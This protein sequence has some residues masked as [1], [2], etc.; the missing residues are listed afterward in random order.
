MKID[1][2]GHFF[3]K[4][5]VEAV[6]KMFANDLVRQCSPYLKLA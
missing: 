5:Y 3:P 2:H 4:S 1:V 6:L